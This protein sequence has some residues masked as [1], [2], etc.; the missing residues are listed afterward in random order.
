MTRKVKT[1]NDYLWQSFVDKKGCLNPNLSLSVM[2]GFPGANP[3]ETRKF[4][5]LPKE[6]VPKSS[7]S[8]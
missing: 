5:L 2:S 6:K 8:E 3:R 1:K 4:G 7:G